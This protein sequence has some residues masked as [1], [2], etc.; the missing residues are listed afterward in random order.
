LELLGTLILS[1]LALIAGVTAHA[2]LTRRWMTFPSVMNL[3]KPR[4]WCDSRFLEPGSV[5]EKA[6]NAGAVREAA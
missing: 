5:A 6:A 1:V 3:D 4:V 2:V